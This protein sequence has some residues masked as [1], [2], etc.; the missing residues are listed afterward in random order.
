MCVRF[1]SSTAAACC[2]QN[3]E[4]KIKY[5]DVFIYI[6]YIKLDVFLDGNDYHGCVL[7]TERCDPKYILVSGLI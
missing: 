6:V 3:A 2:G 4:T 5:I 1:S 7:T